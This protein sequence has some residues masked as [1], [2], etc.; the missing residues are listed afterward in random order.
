MNPEA[1]QEI[2]YI[3]R[4]MTYFIL[5]TPASERKL[6]GRKLAK[7]AGAPNLTPQ[8]HLEKR[9]ENWLLHMKGHQGPLSTNILKWEKD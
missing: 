2:M 3:P 5:P 6:P 1:P 9:A 7:A 8:T 4:W